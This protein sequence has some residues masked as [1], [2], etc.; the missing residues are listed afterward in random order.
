[1][2][3]QVQYNV[4]AV[5]N[6]PGLCSRYGNVLGQLDVAAGAQRRGKPLCCADLFP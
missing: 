3:V 2:I 6:R 1:M 5:P 4:D